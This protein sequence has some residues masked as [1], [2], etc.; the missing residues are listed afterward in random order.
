MTTRMMKNDTGTRLSNPNTIRD[1]NVQRHD[2][3]LFWQIQINDCTMKRKEATT[4][5]QQQ[6]QEQQRIPI[7]YLPP[8]CSP[9][10]PT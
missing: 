6:Q 5:K 10:P 7:T 3:F 4:A 2:A 9:I 8:P 1:Q